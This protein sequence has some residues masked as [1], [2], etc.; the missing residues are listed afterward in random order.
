MVV[1]Q[2]QSGI[3][4]KN[5]PLSANRL[6]K[7]CVVSS[8]RCPSACSLQ[9]YFSAKMP[10]FG[11]AIAH[12]GGPALRPRSATDEHPRN[13]DAPTESAGTRFVKASMTFRDTVQLS[14][15]RDL[16]SIA[17]RVLHALSDKHHKNGGV[18]LQI[19]GR[20]CHTACRG[21]GGPPA[22]P[23]QA[24]G[25]LRGHILYSAR[26]TALDPAVGGAPKLRMALNDR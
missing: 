18:C 10:C 2:C 7:S 26:P 24:N 3:P 16:K 4:A 21:L 1:H 25:S 17:R 9:G 5:K 6:D 14:T 19:P 13:C 12:I 11:R 23:A 8:R 22:T 15:Q 20:G